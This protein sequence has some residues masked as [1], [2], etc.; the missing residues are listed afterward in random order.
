MADPILIERSP[1]RGLSFH[2]A[3]LENPLGV[4]KI[5][6]EENPLPG[7]LASLDDGSEIHRLGCGEAAIDT[8]LTLSAARS[9][10]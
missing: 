10:R 5:P 7:P 8:I 2:I 3:H 4:Q 1:P 9:R 6:I